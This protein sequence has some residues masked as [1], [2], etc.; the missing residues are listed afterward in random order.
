[1]ANYGRTAHNNAINLCD[2]M[3]LI[4]IATAHTL[5]HTHTLFLSLS[6]FHSHSLTRAVRNSFCRVALSF[7]SFNRACHF[8]L[9]LNTA[10]SAAH[11]VAELKNASG[12]CQIANA[13]EYS[14]AFGDEIN[15]AAPARAAC[16]ATCSATCTATRIAACIHR[17]ERVARLDDRRRWQSDNVLPFISL[18]P[19]PFVYAVIRA[20]SYPVAVRN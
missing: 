19:K 12:Q 5:S 14:A 1:M 8:R 10:F 20:T 9:L 13:N 16:A 11:R 6:L 15:D 3:P 2:Q 18:W 7:V 4:Q 17:V